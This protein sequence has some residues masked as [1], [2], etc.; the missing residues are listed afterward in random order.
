MGEW[1]AI[2]KVVHA[3]HTST[4][5]KAGLKYYELR[6]ASGVAKLVREIAG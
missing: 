5:T 6:D 4:S 3:G 2:S 1:H